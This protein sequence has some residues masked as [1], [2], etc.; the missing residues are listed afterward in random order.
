MPTVPAALLLLAT[1]ASE[2]GGDPRI[3][4]QDGIIDNLYVSPAFH[5][6]L[7]LTVVV[8]LLAT[9]A[10]LVAL[11]VRRRG[12]DL[13]GRLLLVGTQ[14]VLMVQV[15][16][17][18]KLLDQGLGTAQLYIHYVGGVLPLGGFLAASWIGWRSDETRARALAVLTVLGT[19][20]AIG[21]YVIGGAYV[22]GSL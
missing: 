19:L 22:R 2:G 20:S 8:L 14:V 10:W 11:G 4:P 1:E 21:A 18:I 17:G 6:T 3:A 12:L 15:L 7:G 13:P 5:R 9:S 16:V